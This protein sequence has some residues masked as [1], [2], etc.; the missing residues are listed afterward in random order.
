MLNVLDLWSWK[1]QE[2]IK[3]FAEVVSY[4]LY[5]KSKNF[6]TFLLNVLALWSCKKSKND[7]IFEEVVPICIL[8]VQKFQHFVKRSS[9][10]IMIMK[11]S[12]NDQNFWRSSSFL[13]YFES[14]KISTKICGKNLT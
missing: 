12:K 5:F 9:C 11:N 13:Y 14:Q 10:F 8:K 3:F 6:P 7:Q 2:M 4:Y 1:I